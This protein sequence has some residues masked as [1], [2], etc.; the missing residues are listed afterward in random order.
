MIKLNNDKLVKKMLNPLYCHRGNELKFRVS[1]N[2]P[3][4]M[5]ANNNTCHTNKHATKTS[6][7]SIT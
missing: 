7:I 5:G 1:I 4:T 2:L 3:G 6:N